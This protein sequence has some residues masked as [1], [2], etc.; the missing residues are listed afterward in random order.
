MKKISKHN[1]FTLT[2]VLVYITVLTVIASAAASFFLWINRSNAKSRAIRESIDN[3]RRAMHIISHEIRE[4]S[5]IY[6]PTCSFSTTSSQLSLET[7]NY[8]PSGESRTYI[9]FFICGKQLCL[10]KEGQDP[11]AITSENV[12]VERL[13]FNQISTTSTAPSIQI[14]LGIE[15]NTPS[16][17]SEE[18]FSVN[19]T[20]TAS[21]RA[22]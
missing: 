12:K 13:E 3:S 20:S 8:L 19:T 16:L 22:Y 17:R 11:I 15:Y 2:E 21:L 4:A 10:K 7:S 5:G 9:D 1:G 6:T 14:G 18:Q